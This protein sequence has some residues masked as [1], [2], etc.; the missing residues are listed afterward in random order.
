MSEC[1]NFDLIFLIGAP[2]SGTTW[3]QLLLSSHK[4]ITTTRET[5]LY[6]NYI[7]RIMNGWQNELK[8]NSPD[9]LHTFL[10]NAEFLDVVRGFSDRLFHH[11]HQ[12][13][14]SSSIILEKTPAH[15]KYV[16]HLR[17]LYPR[18]RFIQVI[19]DPRAVA[20]SMKNAKAK[21]WGDWVAPTPL[22]SAMRWRRLLEK[23]R[24]IK[25]K[26][27]HDY[28][29]IRYENLHDK[30][31]IFLKLMFDWM[32]IEV[33]EADIEKIVLENDIN[34][35]KEDQEKAPRDSP[36]FENRQDFFRRGQID[37]WRTELTTDEIQDVEGICFNLMKEFDYEPIFYSKQ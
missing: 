11:I 6:D 9:G 24:S 26:L 7:S 18:S 17:E 19:R 4:S 27:S 30:P 16:L 2:R 32:N 3:L 21:D 25:E 15:V 5:H 13:D 29:E 8:Q 14:A 35:L 33:T 1:N 23:R 28:F 10:S 37:S 12:K 36:R 22:D 20:A 34:R 31:N